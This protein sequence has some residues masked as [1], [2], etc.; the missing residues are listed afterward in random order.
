M[1]LPTGGQSSSRDDGTPESD[2]QLA[3]REVEEQIEELEAARD[4]ESEA[5]LKRR[6]GETIAAAQMA[7][8]RDLELLRAGLARRSYGR[9]VEPLRRS[10][11]MKQH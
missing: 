10:A 1:W 4:A 2:P 11:E 3:R 6:A 5:W 8:E 9:D 7:R